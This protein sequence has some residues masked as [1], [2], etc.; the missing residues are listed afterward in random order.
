MHSWHGTTVSGVIAALTDNET[1]IAGVGLSKL[2]V[3]PVRALGYG[4]GTTY[5][6]AQAIRYAAGLDNDSDPPKKPSRTAK[7]INLSLGGGGGDSY[8]EETLAAV[9]AKGIIAVAAA[10]NSRGEYG[11]EEVDY[12]ASSEYTI[13]VAATTYTNTVA[14]YSNPGSL[15]DIS[16]PGG[17]GE[18]D[19]W[20]DWVIT[21]S[22][23]PG[24]DHELTDD[25]YIYL[26]TAGTSI[27]CPHVAGVLA[28]L[29]TVDGRMDL[30]MAKEV[31]RRSATDLGELGWDRDFG[32]GLLNGLAAFG[33]Y[34]L[35]I[36]SGWTGYLETKRSPVR[37]P[38]P[39]D[40][41][42]T[43]EL[44][45]ESLIIRYVTEGAAKSIGSAGRLR[46]LGALP[47]AKSF[48]RDLVVKPEAGVD[49]VDLRARL[50]AEP[51]IE[52]VFYNYRYRP[53]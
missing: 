1:G 31:L 7:I 29:C 49:P 22:P 33:A 28:L 6:I 36:D 37:K 4:G 18:R 53:L 48:E 3:L 52:A 40:A 44:A 16:A 51:E 42:P 19:E 2:K 5:D 23:D 24:A 10:G 35:L 13:A 14:P 50:L 45:E 17:R 47:T 27:A 9:T 34:R 38:L 41:E 21:V 8:F 26:G 20:T 30:A 25:D 43:G 39:A 12:P 11:V 46:A 32:H 15:V